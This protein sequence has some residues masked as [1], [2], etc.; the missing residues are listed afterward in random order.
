MTG[1]RVKSSA[2]APAADST[3]DVGQCRQWG[4]KATSAV[5]P[6]DLLLVSLDF[7]RS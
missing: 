5:I 6:P 7:D 1:I 3:P 4:T 2:F